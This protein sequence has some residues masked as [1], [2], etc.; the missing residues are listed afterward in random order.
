MAGKQV[1]LDGQIIHGRDSYGWWNSLAMEGWDSTPE[2]KTSLTSR[3][4]EDGDFDMPVKYEARTVALNGR[5]IAKDP[6]QARLARRRLTGLLMDGGL[7]SLTDDDGITISANA[8]RGRIA[9]GAVRGRFLTFQMELR[10]PDPYKYGHARTVPLT[11][12][13]SVGLFHR[14]N[15]RAWPLVRVTGSFPN[16]YTLNGPGGKRFVVLTNPG[17]GTHLLDMRQGLLQVNGN[18]FT[19][20]T[21][22]TDVWSVAPGQESA[23]S[24]TA[25]SGSGSAVITLTDTYI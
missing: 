3:V 10:F 21:S 1:M 14:G 7:F 23:M 13:G 17:S 5:L 24:L 8:R 15:A 12:G 18:Y 16:G 9:P 20:Q 2:P 22:Q 19:G 4:N 6:A 25:S 11:I